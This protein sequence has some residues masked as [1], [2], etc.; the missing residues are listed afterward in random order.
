VNPIGIRSCYDEGKRAAETLCFDYHRQHGVDIRVVRIFNTYGPRMAPDDGRVVSNFIVQALKGEDL[1]VYGK[2]DQTRSFCYVDDLISG[3]T[4]FSDTPQ[5]TGPL[6]I[7]NDAE[8]TILE[9]AS[10]V[11]AKVGGQSKIDFRPL[12]K[13]DPK[14]RR[15]H[16]ETTK[17]TLKGWAPSVSLDKGL[18]HTIRYFSELL[19]NRNLDLNKNRN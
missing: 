5:V 10:K 11:L 18:D 7:G 8:F 9:L 12:P 3:I 1:T 16:L 15:P 19:G 4:K 14:C 6:N 2:G 17:T 13:D